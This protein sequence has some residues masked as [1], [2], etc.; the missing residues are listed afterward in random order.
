[1]N[2]RTRHHHKDN[3]INDEENADMVPISKEINKK[4][5]IKDEQEIQEKEQSTLHFAGYVGIGRRLAIFYIDLFF[6]WL[7][8]VNLYL[9]FR[10][11]ETL[12]RKFFAVKIIHAYSGELPS[13][14]SL[15]FRFIFKVLNILTLGLSFIFILKNERKQGIHDKI[16]TT[17]VVKTE[18]KR[19]WGV[20]V[21]GLLPFLI[22]LFLVF[23][24]WDEYDRTGQ[25]SFI[26]NNYK[27]KDFYD[28]KIKGNDIFQEKEE[29]VSA[30]NEDE[31]E[32]EKEESVFTGDDEEEFIPVENED[33]EDSVSTENGRKVY[34]LDEDGFVPSVRPLDY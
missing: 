1:M 4:E 10:K 23:N 24:L 27:I 28:D 21:F 12:G 34:E 9:Y 30:E 32:D 31:N 14:S 8:P 16:S 6:I 29:N 26:E 7:F 33:K 19:L 11:G 5:D 22:T 25:I 3:E 20:Y 18:E 17:V 13:F 2:K 15:L